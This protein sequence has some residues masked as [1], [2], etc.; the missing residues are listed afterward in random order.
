MDL[1]SVM[2]EKFV[3]IVE[4]KRASTGQAMKQCVLSLK[5][6]WDN[7]EGGEVYGF[8]TSGNQWRMFKF[9]GKSFVAT[10]EFMVLFESMKED[11]KRWTKNIFSCGGLCIFCVELRNHQGQGCLRIGDCSLGSVG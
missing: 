8:V 7:N 10:E 3:L 4:A 1:I 6:A 5:D 2:E 9:D 11:K